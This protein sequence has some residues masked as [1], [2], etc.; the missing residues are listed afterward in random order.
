[1]NPLQYEIVLVKKGLFLYTVC[2][3]K[4]ERYMNNSKHHHF[5]FFIQCLW[6][7]IIDVKIITV[8]QLFTMEVPTKLKRKSLNL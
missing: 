6:G 4:T 5:P 1:M 7:F 2:P 8:L 3:E